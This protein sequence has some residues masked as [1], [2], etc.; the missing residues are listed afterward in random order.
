MI[1]GSSC[2][3]VRFCTHGAHWI[4]PPFGV[5]VFL[6]KIKSVFQSLTGQKIRLGPRGGLHRWHHHFLEKQD[7]SINMAL[8]C[9]F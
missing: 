3:G 5:R 9:F 7:G 1:Q 2:M 6:Y 4:Y 8:L